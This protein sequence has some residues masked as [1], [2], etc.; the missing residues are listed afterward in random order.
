MNKDRII[1]RLR[2]E[3][4]RITKQ[5]KIL[6]DII[7]NDDCV[8]CKEIYYKASKIDKSIGSATVYR[9]INTLEDIGAITRNSMYQIEDDLNMACSEECN[10]D[11]IKD[12]EKCLIELNDGT[13]LRLLPDQWN[14]IIE[15]GLKMQG[16][17]KN[18]QNIKNVV[19]SRV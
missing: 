2:Q 16:Y 4:F 10:G 7:L 13:A 5:R 18:N 11:C 1:Q 15:A 9:M 6:L 17:L 19:V 3:G 14:R 8:C 12:C